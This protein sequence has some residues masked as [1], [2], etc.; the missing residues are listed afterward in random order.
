MPKEHADADERDQG[1]PPQAQPPQEHCSNLSSKRTCAQLSEADQ[2]IN[3]KENSTG[4]GGFETDEAEPPLKQ[5]RSTEQSAEDVEHPKQVHAT[6]T[7][8]LAPY[9]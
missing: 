4:P 8:L 6:C 5:A 9:F 3:L 1:E 7:L 2:Q